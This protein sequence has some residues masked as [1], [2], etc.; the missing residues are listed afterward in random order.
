VTIAV[1][2]TIAFFPGLLAIS[3][4]IALLVHV[5]RTRPYPRSRP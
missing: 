1:V 3:F 5:H 2:W 4:G